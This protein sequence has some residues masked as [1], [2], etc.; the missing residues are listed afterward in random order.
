MN[1]RGSA[2][3]AEVQRRRKW[4]LF[5]SATSPTSCKGLECAPDPE[6]LREWAPFDSDGF[7]GCRWHATLSTV[8]APTPGVRLA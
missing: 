8:G 7:L 6:H 2:S 1:T 5:S 3:G 4:T